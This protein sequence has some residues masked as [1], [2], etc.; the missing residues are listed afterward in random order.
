MRQTAATLSFGQVDTLVGKNNAGPSER[1][2]KVREEL[3]KQGIDLALPIVAWSD[4][5]RQ[6]Y[7]YRNRKE[8]DPYPTGDH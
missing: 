2:P 7:H 1:H 5:A 3:A 8:G 6:L 4:G